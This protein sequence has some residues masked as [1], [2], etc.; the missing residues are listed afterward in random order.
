VS[1]YIVH[2]TRCFEYVLAM[3]VPIVFFRLLYPA[4]RVVLLA[5]TYRIC[6][7]DVCIAYRIPT[8]QVHIPAGW[9][10]LFPRA[11][12]IINNISISPSL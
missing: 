4:C 12:E 9:F 10:L 7:S 8:A 3:C 11:M 2:M 6:A 5:Y 1:P